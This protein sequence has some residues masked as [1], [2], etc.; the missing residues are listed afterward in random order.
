MDIVV[1]KNVIVPMRDGINLAA[2]VLCHTS[3]VVL[4]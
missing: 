1:E 4:Q 2:D 3:E